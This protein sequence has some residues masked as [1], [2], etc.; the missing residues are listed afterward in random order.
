MGDSDMYSSVYCIWIA[1]ALLGVAM[2]VWVVSDANKRGANGCLWGLI[3][4]FGNWLGLLVY[5]AVRGNLGQKAK[6]SPL[7]I[8][9][10]RLAAGEID[11]EEYHRLVMIMDSPAEKRK[12]DFPE[13]YR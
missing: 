7:A 5:L 11:E 2:V 8:L 12:R 6:E 3:V 13:D 9:Q 10:R 1:F 4:I